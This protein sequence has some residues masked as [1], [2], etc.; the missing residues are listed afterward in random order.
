M[1]LDESFYTQSDPTKQGFFDV[2]TVKV[3][4]RDLKVMRGLLEAGLRA[5]KRFQPEI[6]TAA[7]A[8]SE[9]AKEVAN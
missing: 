8:G 6:I 7:R 2:L 1:S 9:F 4:G 3:D 5:V